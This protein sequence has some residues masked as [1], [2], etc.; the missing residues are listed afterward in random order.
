MKCLRT[1]LGEPA[2]I[3]ARNGPDGVLEEPQFFGESGMGGGEDK[4]THDD[5]RVAVDVFGEGVHDDVG[6]EKQRRGVE[7]RE[8][9]VVNKDDGSGGVRAGNAGDTGD[10]D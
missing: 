1:A 5:V 6:A 8:E 9:G 2:I 7:G 4:S 10:V 3:R